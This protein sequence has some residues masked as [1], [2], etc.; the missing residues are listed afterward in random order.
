M[1][2]RL[3][4]PQLIVYDMDGTLTLPFLDFDAIR[5]DLGLNQGTILEHL[6]T[7]NETDRQAA[8]LILEQHEA[9]A[10]EEV[11]LQP[12][13][14]E[15]VDFFREAGVH[16]AILTRNSRRSVARLVER[17]QLPISHWYTR[18]DGP[19][20]PD[21]QPI[22]DLCRS[23]NTTPANCWMVGDYLYDIQCGRSAGASTVLMLG[24]AVIPEYAD[25]ADLVIRELRELLNAYELSGTT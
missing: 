22:H 9:R 12:G 13:A 16:Q 17:F 14:H 24:D 15:V 10:A 21:P 20:K 3:P 8:T 19:V 6:R 4:A 23:L 5:R 7:L 2:N 25:L 1:P 11:G 18:E